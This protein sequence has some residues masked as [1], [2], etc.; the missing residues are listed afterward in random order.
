[1]N[2]STRIHE[3]EFLRHYQYSTLPYFHSIL[4]ITE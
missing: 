4:G 3:R 1:M 2:G